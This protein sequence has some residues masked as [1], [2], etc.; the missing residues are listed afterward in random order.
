MNIL[1]TIPICA[2]LAA[3]FGLI[4]RIANKPAPVPEIV[5]ETPVSELSFRD[6]VLGGDR[7]EIYH[8]AI[9][10]A[11]YTA[12]KEITRTGC[13]GYITAL[14]SQ[15]EE[16]DEGAAFVALEATRQTAKR[17]GV[18]SRVEKALSDAERKITEAGE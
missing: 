18:L 4:I 8:N 13:G 17:W 15:C 16:I 6:R 3:F 14:L 9:Y 11:L 5:E 1:L 12:R 10:N 7:V 2:L